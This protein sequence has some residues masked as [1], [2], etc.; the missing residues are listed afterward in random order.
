MRKQD[1]YY[2]GRRLSDFGAVVSDIVNYTV[3]V[4]ELDFTSVPGKSGDIITDKKRFKNMTI[5]YKISH[6]PTWDDM[7]EQTFVDVLTEWLLSDYDYCVLRDS[8]YKGYFRRAV[9]TG[10]S[11]CESPCIAVVSAT[12]TFNCMPFWYSDAGT[13]VITKESSDN[14]LSMSITNREKWKSEPVIRIIGSGDFACRIGNSSFEIFDVTDE[15]TID[16]PQENVYDGSGTPCN[17][18]VSAVSLPI[19]SP[20]NNTITIMNTTQNF[21]V[22]ITPNWRRI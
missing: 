10:I 16:K 11:K 19:L 5:S 18:K 6:V 14:V 1:I 21:S 2:R 7:D 13:N 20:G 17:N 3:A 12:V 15:I 22:E 4:R 9:C 8:M